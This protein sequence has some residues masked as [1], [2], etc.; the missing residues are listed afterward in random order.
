MAQEVDVPALPEMT[1][2]KRPDPVVR[3][4]GVRDIAEAF[5]AGLR[6]FQRAPGYGLL[7]G[8]F[9]AAGGILLVLLATRLHMAYLIYP[10]AA[11]FA[12]LGPFIATGLYEISRRLERGQ[13]LTLS[14]ICGVIFAQ[15]R[16]ELGWMAFVT[17]FIFLIWMYQIRLLLALFLG[18]KSFSSMGEFV[19]IVLTTPEGLLFLLIGNIVGAVLALVLFS[20]TVVSFPLLLDRE[21]DFITAMITS[22]RAVVVNLVPMI[23]WAA[24]VVMLLIA[25]ALPAFLGLIVV[26]PILGFTTW[27]LYRRVVEPLPDQAG[28]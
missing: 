1:P 21:L 10:L 5:A 9:Y 13:P 7:F 19:S 11:G 14:G 20:L 23:G 26:L 27:H 6:D 17:L 22:V 16:R 18:F 15:S 12:L 2:A 28:S 8:S 24:I 25:A 4:I 3:S